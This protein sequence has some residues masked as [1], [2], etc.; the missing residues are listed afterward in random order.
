[1]P[2]ECAGMCTGHGLNAIYSITNVPVLEYIPLVAISIST[3]VAKHIVSDC[4]KMSLNSQNIRNE[5]AV[6]SKS[7]IVFTAVLQFCPAACKHFR[8]HSKLTIMVWSY[9]SHALH[10]DLQNGN[11]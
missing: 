1:M 11:C 4:S 9:R 7:S 3:G 8:I 2:A 10:L 6:Y 5:C